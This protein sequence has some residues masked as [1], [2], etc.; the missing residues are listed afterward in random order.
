MVTLFTGRGQRLKMMDVLGPCC[1]FPM[2]DSRNDLYLLQNDPL[3]WMRFFKIRIVM[4]NYSQWTQHP[5]HL[6]SFLRYQIYIIVWRLSLSNPTFSPFIFH[7]NNFLVN[8]CISKSILVFVSLWRIPCVRI[9][10]RKQRVH[11]K[12]VSRSLIKGLVRKH[13]QGLGSN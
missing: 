8:L 11:L 6:L 9:P 1:F 7:G 10:S 13:R 12:W 3:D 4:W 5:P 2:E